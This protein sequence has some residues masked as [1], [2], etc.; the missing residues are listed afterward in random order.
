MTTKALFMTALGGP[1]MP[2]GIP[3]EF[4]RSSGNI[5]TAA[6]HGLNSG[7]GPYKA[8]TTNAD[9][10]SGITAAVRSSLAYTPSTDVQDE[11]VTIDTKVY[12]WRD[13]PST[14]DGQV[15]V[16]ADNDI[17]AENLSQA[18]NLGAGA[19]TNYSRDMTG[20]P[21]VSASVRSGVVTVSAKVLDA[22]I[23]DAIVVAE[24]AAGA[25]AGGGVLLD[26]GVDGTDYFIIRL[27]ANTFSVAT[28]KANAIAGTVVALSDAGT[29]VH[30]LVPVV[31]TLA[32]AM[33]DV[34][35][36][37]LTAT[38]AKSYPAAL[39]ISNYW[40]TLIDGVSGNDS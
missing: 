10:P 16:N 32:D 34:L 23:G 4:V 17:A 25:W 21:N 3:K 1:K 15:D 33:D 28:S 29:G 40:G 2:L 14:G 30:T 11:T 36:N 5:L 38:G 20:N 27:S 22:T 7:A 24:S 31:E 19:A 35:T 26:N 37:Y 39:N 8:M 12:T 9:A 6:A 18:I 13:S